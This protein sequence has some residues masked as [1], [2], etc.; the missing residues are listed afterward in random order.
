MLDEVARGFLGE[1][2]DRLS[3]SKQAETRLS[4]EA[5]PSER[6]LRESHVDQQ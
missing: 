5:D 6:E 4:L 1:R 2:K 3:L